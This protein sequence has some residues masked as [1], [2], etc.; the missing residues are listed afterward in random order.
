[1][2]FHRLQLK[3]AEAVA[4]T[5]CCVGAQENMVEVFRRATVGGSPY[6]F[7]EDECGRP[8]GLI[9]KEEILQKVAKP[10]PGELQEWLQ[11]P[12]E[13]MLRSRIDAPQSAATPASASTLPDQSALSS[14]RA[15]CVD[16]DGRLLGLITD[17]DVLIS[18]QSIQR[19]LQNSQGDAVTGLPNRASFD[20]HLQAEFNRGLR[21]GQS[22]SVVLVDLD[23][24]KQ[25]NDQFGHQAGDTALRTIAE[26]L[27]QSLRSYD[28]VA[29]Y[30]GD[31]LAVICSGCRPGE[32]DIIVRRV[33]EVV[34]QL[35]TRAV[36]E[37]PLPTISVGAAVVHQLDLLSDAARLVS[38]ADECLYA[39]KAAGRNC[40]FK[41]ELCNDSVVRPLMVHDR[42]THQP[43]QN[44][45]GPR[46]R[47]AESVC[48]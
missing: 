35:Q 30:G 25:V 46:S 19:T 33:R 37:M 24:F 28:L 5:D 18:W 3:S 47:Y 26:T 14:G 2:E 20:A 21:S 48:P 44:G 12:V 40:A 9:A 31:E 1:M 36:G 22:V 41:T 16:V 45:L 10:E 8:V 15:I 43:V 42:F 32:I 38:A 39:A 6:L 23:Y 17:Q 4:G 13:S 11:R 27:R 7:V 34:L 29:R